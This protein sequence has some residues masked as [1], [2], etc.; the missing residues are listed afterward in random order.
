MITNRFREG[1]VTRANRV[2]HLSVQLTH[3]RNTFGVNGEPFLQCKLSNGCVSR[4]CFYNFIVV[5]SCRVVTSQTQLVA[6]RLLF[7]FTFNGI[8]D[9]QIITCKLSV[10]SC[11]MKFRF[12]TSRARALSGRI[13]YHSLLTVSS[14]FHGK[15][16]LLTWV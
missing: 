14:C 2:N 1:W 5:A 12:R 11:N 15:Y 13:I 9:F 3:M 6:V 7:Y 16:S 8:V 10:L 4:E